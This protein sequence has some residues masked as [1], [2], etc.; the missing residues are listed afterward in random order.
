MYNDIIPN[1]KWFILYIYTI[2]WETNICRTIDLFYRTTYN[3]LMFSSCSFAYVFVSCT[4]HNVTVRTTSHNYNNSIQI[5][6]IGHSWESL[7]ILRISRICFTYMSNVWD[8]NW[9]FTEIISMHLSITYFSFIK[10]R[11]LWLSNLLI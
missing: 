6:M 11:S 9:T 2:I 3:I 7:I 10:C 8:S 5:L 4:H 1:Y